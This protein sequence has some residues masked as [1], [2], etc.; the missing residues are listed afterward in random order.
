M[1]PWVIGGAI[2]AVLV[3]FIATNVAVTARQ[4][5][6]TPKFWEDQMDAPV[7]PNAV[8]L[9]ALGDSTVEAIGASRPMD[10]YVGRIAAFVQQK[11]GRPVHITTLA[12]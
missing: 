2:A 8:R 10:G 5:L 11:T 12:A 7:A 9:V 6:A 4:A 3:L 1:S